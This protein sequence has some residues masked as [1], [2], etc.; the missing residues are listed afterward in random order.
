MTFE[1]NMKVLGGVEEGSIFSC[2]RSLLF[3]YDYD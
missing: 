2:G 3:D 1:K